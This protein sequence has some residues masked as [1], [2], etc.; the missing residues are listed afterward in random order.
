M[1]SYLKQY[2]KAIAAFIAGGIVSYLMKHNVIIADNLKDSLEV[3]ISAVITGAVVL[4]A[5]A[6][7]NNREY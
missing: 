2:N 7:K 4:A 6:N 5:P 1:F 3:V